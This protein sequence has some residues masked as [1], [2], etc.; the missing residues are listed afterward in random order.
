MEIS[1]SEAHVSSAE[2]TVDEA[3]LVSTERE[4]S[5]ETEPASSQ[6]FKSTSDSNALSENSAVVLNDV[7][8]PQD[9]LVSE[10]SDVVPDSTIVDSPGVPHIDVASN[11]SSAESENQLDEPDI[12]NIELKHAVVA[13]SDTKLPQDSTS[14]ASSPSTEIEATLSDISDSE[15]I[16]TTKSTANENIITLDSIVAADDAIL[17]H[18]SASGL[19]SA[20]SLDAALNPTSESDDNP[21]VDSVIDEKIEVVTATEVSNQ[22]VLSQGSSVD[23]VSEKIEQ[24]GINDRDK[25]STTITEQSVLPTMIESENLKI[26]RVPKVDDQANEKASN[27]DQ[28]SVFATSADDPGSSTFFDKVV[29]QFDET[30]RLSGRVDVNE[31][32]QPLVNSHDSESYFKTQQSQEN[33]YFATQE[34]DV[35]PN[36]DPFANKDYSGTLEPEEHLFW[37]ETTKNSAQ[38]EIKGDADLEFEFVK[39]EAN[40]FDSGLISLE[41]GIDEKALN[42]S[43]N[44]SPS[45]LKF[46]SNLDFLL[47]DDDFLDSDDENHNVETTPSYQTLVQ[48]PSGYAPQHDISAPSIYA[49]VQQKPFA[50]SNYASQA[51]ADLSSYPHMEAQSAN[52]IYSQ[53]QSAPPK[54]PSS[55]SFFADLPT[56]SD[57]RLTN[58]ISAFEHMVNGD[59]LINNHTT[60]ASHGSHVYSSPF[61]APESNVLSKH[62][63]QAAVPAHTQPP[64]SSSAAAHSDF[65]AELPLKS[66]PLEFSEILSSTHAPAADVVP[67]T[68]L[69][70][71]LESRAVSPYAPIKPIL[72]SPAV[73]HYENSQIVLQQEVNKYAPA[74]TAGPSV[75]NPYVPQAVPAPLVPPPE[76]SRYVVPPP[77]APSTSVSPVVN[78][79]APVSQPADVSK[80]PFSY[81]SQLQS[82][83]RYFNS[84][85][86]AVGAN[87][88]VSQLQHSS[89][90]STSPSNSRY[91]PQTDNKTLH[92]SFKNITAPSSPPQTYNQPPFTQPTEAKSIL[93]SQFKMS[94]IP[95]N[96]ASSTENDLHH[97]PIVTSA[98][99]QPYGQL[100]TQQQQRPGISGYTAPSRSSSYGYQPSH[101][102]VK[103]IGSEI[104]AI[105]PSSRLV[106][107]HTK[108]LLTPQEPVIPYVPSS[109][110]SVY[111]TS[112]ALFSWGAN[113][114][115]VTIFPLK[116]NNLGYTSENLSFSTSKVQ[117]RNAK[118]FIFGVNG[119]IN[120]KFPGPVFSPGSKSANKTKKKEVLKWMDEK[121][122]TID[123]ESYSAT[124]QEKV[125]LKEKNIL[126]KSVRL[127]LECDGSLEGTSEL[128]NK[129]RMILTPGL[130]DDANSD[131]YSSFSNAGDLYAK[132][133]GGTALVSHDTAS[134][135]KI[136]AISEI[137]QFLLRGNREG[138]VSAA[139][140]NRLFE[141][142]MLISSTIS[143]QRFRETAREFVRSEISSLGSLDY[144][145]L[146][147]VYEVFAGL[148]AESVDDL[149]QPGSNMPII[150]AN[151]LSIEAPAHLTKW[152]ESLSM[153]LSNR[154]EGDTTAV[155]SLGTLLASYGFTYAAHTC[156]LFS[157]SLAI[158]GPI[159]D[160]RSAF[161]LVGAD[162]TKNP[163]LF[164]KDLDSIILSEIYELA[165]SLG[166]NTVNGGLIPHLQLFKLQHAL[167]LA[168]YGLL[169]DARKFCDHIQAEIKVT[170]KTMFVYNKSFIQSVRDLGHRLSESPTTGSS[171]LGSKLSK[172]SLDKVWGQLDKSFAKFVSGDD[173]DTPDGNGQGEKNDGR[174]GKIASSPAISRPQ[175]ALDISGINNFSPQYVPSQTPPNTSNS[176]NPRSYGSSPSSVRASVYVQHD[177]PTDIVGGYHAANSQF[178]YDHY[179]VSSP[180]S[181]TSSAA[182]FESRSSFEISSHEL[183]SRRESYERVNRESEQESISYEPSNA[184]YTSLS[185]PTSINAYQ[186]SDGLRKTSYGYEPPSTKFE[187]PSTSYNPSFTS[188]EP[189]ST[190]YQPPSTIYEPQLVASEYENPSEVNLQQA[191]IYNATSVEENQASY[192]GYE[193]NGGDAAE[194]VDNIARESYLDDEFEDD[195]GLGNNA[196]Q[197]KTPEVA[198]EEEKEKKEV[199]KEQV[200]KL[201][202]G[203]PQ[204]KGWFGW[205]RKGNDQEGQ[206]QQ[207]K[208]IRAKLGEENSF[209]YDPE[210]KRWINKKASLDNAPAAVPPPPPKKKLAPSTT[211]EPTSMTSSLS[212]ARSPVPGPPIASQSSTS[213]PFRSGLTPPTSGS[214]ARL[215]PS[216]SMPSLTGMPEIPSG[217]RTTRK[218][219][220]YI[221]PPAL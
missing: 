22:T 170:P 48:S 139:L 116:N 74:H 35:Q 40:P 126:W 157:R 83:D 110:R 121:I 133:V 208:A 60:T 124:G 72:S 113:G 24:F 117:I 217:T 211:P 100:P 43:T 17:P 20:P 29:S 30:L 33:N 214:Q 109:N 161:T 184:D 105:Q 79:Y 1:V 88:D 54:K 39:A 52:N 18:D 216:N 178:A 194:I 38:S 26:E 2:T 3:A 42:D 148:G 58:T 141:H 128:E 203:K 53:L 68:D 119:D 32:P 31:D 195:L 76:Q 179:R 81:L 215:P 71:F 99:P 12:E 28:F 11:R 21:K 197:K 84:T 123:N 75:F 204:S 69:T 14:I 15:N 145:S 147:L 96:V 166:S 191:D 41:G 169:A 183:R 210:Q 182:P 55:N 173:D 130:S 90:Y 200:D 5:L 97:V 51:T 155:Y 70:Q 221:P 25:S 111:P 91:L 186:S 146:A 209:Y 162:Y 45:E 63:S 180:G 154:S 65:F 125:Q 103:S 190:A 37:N 193:P 131:G 199:N 171:W 50:S 8:L 150:P 6:H 120:L 85:E 115:I 98:P 160:A 135:G 62:H 101:Q 87:V 23:E 198:E 192:V 151:A 77:S 86:P 108:A 4:S 137:K 82:R 80:P 106:S 129:I 9:K 78:P 159:D 114:K 49:P 94:N 143:K 187:P 158:F 156:F 177:Q 61:D 57:P 168:D 188:Y 67:L 44:S 165:L 149:L 89:S 122:Q 102:S 212:T 27:N 213:L 205:L 218:R 36:Y 56:I 219:P 10:N 47:E 66:N 152:S 174:F 59:T 142:A 164:S 175:S 118:D 206:Q 172:P 132:H 181:Q 153:I 220:K 13:L 7:E 64:R 189:P 112:H 163:L 92:A 176:Y 34:D 185:Y 134:K 201:Q 16:Q 19:Y 104:V 138:A 202:E 167:I 95:P 107:A 207:Q 136:D 196:L 127:V 144:H 46:D 73:N 93:P 140:D